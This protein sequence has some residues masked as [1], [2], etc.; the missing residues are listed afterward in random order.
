MAQG[1]P[2]KVG[3]DGNVLPLK[4]ASMVKLRR[5][6]HIGDA[7]YH[8]VHRGGC[9]IPK[10]VVLPRDAIILGPVPEGTPIPMPTADLAKQAAA[11][12]IAE[13]KLE[14]DRIIAAA[15]GE[16]SEADSAPIE[17]EIDDDKADGEKITEKKAGK[18]GK[19][20]L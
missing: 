9:A 6:F 19:L 18:Q 13:A 16:T 5:S 14:A 12:I 3:K 7:A 4:E 11:E 17:V 20:D 15:R 1:E 8:P 10:G 2:V